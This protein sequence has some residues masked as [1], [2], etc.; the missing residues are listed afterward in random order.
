MILGSQDSSVGIAEGY[1]LK[2]GGGCLIPNMGKEFGLSSTASRPALR[3]TQ[4]LGYCILDTEG[5]ESDHSSFSTA[6]VKNGGAVPLLRHMSSWRG[7]QLSTG[8][9]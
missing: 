2:G 8:T 9:T 7:V 4:R 3:Q 1:G 6:K 5:R